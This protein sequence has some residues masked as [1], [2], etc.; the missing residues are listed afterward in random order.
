MALRTPLKIG[1][2]IL[3]LWPLLPAASRAP[4]YGRLL[5][6]LVRDARV[7]WSSKALLGLAVAYVASPVD[8]IPDSVPVIGGMDD[9]VVAV[10]S[11]D[12]FLESVPRA[13]MIEKMYSL[14]I[15]GRELERDLESIR[16]VVPRPLR[17]AARRL[18]EAID[19]G[20]TA[21]R[22]EIALRRTHR[23]DRLDRASALWHKHQS[24]V[25]EEFSA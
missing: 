8:L 22:R 25:K 15:D 4:L 6:E 18:P 7:P 5:F 12:L 20:A 23:P 14:G 16:R 21:I 24:Q 13:L 9:L 3:S 1:L 11:V 19:H 2:S 10:I 17:M